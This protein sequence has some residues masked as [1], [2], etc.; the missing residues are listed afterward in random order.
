M[1]QDLTLT[2]V[3]VGTGTADEEGQLVFVG[4]LLVAVLVHLAQGH[5]KAGHWFLEHG[6][7]SLNV[8]VPPTFC[9][10]QAAENWIGHRLGGAVDG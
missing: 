2:P 8:P 6:F 4:S 10:L 1:I 3:R 7:G 9:G 5:D